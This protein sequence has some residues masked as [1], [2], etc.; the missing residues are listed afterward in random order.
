[1]RYS[2]ILVLSLV[3]LSMMMPSDTMAQR[4]PRRKVRG[5]YAFPG[6]TLVLPRDRIATMHYD[7]VPDDAV[8]AGFWR[9]RRRTQ[10]ITIT[11]P[12]TASTFVGVVVD[13]N[14]I[15]GLYT[16]AKW[17]GGASIPLELNRIDIDTQIIH[18]MLIRRAGG[19][20]ARGIVFYDFHRNRQD[21]RGQFRIVVY[22]RPSIADT[23]TLEHRTTRK[24]KR[25]RR[26]GFWR[27]RLRRDYNVVEAYLIHKDHFDAIPQQ[28]DDF[29]ALTVDGVNVRAMDIRDRGYRWRLP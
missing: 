21:Q 17:T 9:F 20:F 26:L 14:T 15:T 27:M 25:L 5:Q 12:V 16:S 19:R 10:S 4:I 18:H 8:D 2:L 29:P 24:R 6:G 28:T 13:I 22:S 11:W 23:A 7:G 1:M 3:S